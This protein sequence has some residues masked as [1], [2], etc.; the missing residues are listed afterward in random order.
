MNHD[1]TAPSL[2]AEIA[3]IDAAMAEMRNVHPPLT[4]SDCRRLIRAA[5]AAPAPEARCTCPSGDGSLRWP[6]P[7]HPPRHQVDAVGVMTYGEAAAAIGINSAIL[8]IEAGDAGGALAPLRGVARVL[9]A[10]PHGPA[11]PTAAAAAYA[12][13]KSWR[14]EV[15]RLSQFAT[16]AMH[17]SER[18][19]RNCLDDIAQR[20]AAMLHEDAAPAPA[21]RE[22][23]GAATAQDADAVDGARHRAWRRAITSGDQGFLERV[24]D[25]L[26]NDEQQLPTEQEWDAAIDAARA[27]QEGAGA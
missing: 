1:Y 6:C 8:R 16:T 18:D 26:P 3:M 21:V 24:N 11:A 13:P 19:K 9:A 27:R 25:A 22:A 4:R 14:D 15:Q 2:A 5:L 10:A 20:L 23:L 17:M 12:P 7:D